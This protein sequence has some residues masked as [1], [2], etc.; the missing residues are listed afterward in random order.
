MAFC[1]LQ[2][3]PQRPAPDHVR[4][5]ARVCRADCGAVRFEYR[6]TGRIEPLRIP[7]PASSEPTDGLWQHTCLEAFVAREGEAG[8]VELNFSASSQ[9]ARYAFSGERVRDPSAEADGGV[10]PGPV[11]ECTVQPDELFLSATV[12]ASWLPEQPWRVGLTAVLEASD[13]SLSYWALHHPRP[14]PDFH[15]ADGRCLRVASL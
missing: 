14:Q 9:W 12:P 4:V 1:E 8:Y 10:E 15:H 6:V 3:H 11:I 2:A 13:G 5:L 7:A